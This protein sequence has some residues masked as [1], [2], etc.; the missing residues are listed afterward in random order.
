VSKFTTY[1]CTLEAAI[2]VASNLRP[3]DRREIEEGH[4]DDP[5][6]VLPNAIHNGFCVYFTAPNGKTAGMGGVTEEGAIWMMC[7]PVIHDYPIAF[8]K[9]AKRV[10][11][12][13]TEKLLWNI[14]DKRNTVHLRLLKNLGFKFLR[15]FPY[16]PNQLTFIEFCKICAQ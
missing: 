15:E 1:P 4:G 2:E 12:S 6:E 9:E 16:G 7:T 8:V 14:V 13:R 11:N 3:E 5:M 10:L